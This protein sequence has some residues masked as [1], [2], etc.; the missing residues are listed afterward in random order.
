MKTLGGLLLLAL[1]GWAIA[2]FATLVGLR[3][4][5]DLGW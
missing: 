4:L 2:L 5:S 1:A 3:L